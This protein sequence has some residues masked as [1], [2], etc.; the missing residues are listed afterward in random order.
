M[1]PARPAAVVVLAAGEG[2]RMKSSIPKVLHPLGGRTP[3]RPR[4]RRRR[5][6]SSPSTSSSSSATAA[7]RSR[8]TWPRSPPRRVT[9][10]QDEQPAPATPSQCALDGAA[11]DLDRHRRG[12]LRRRAAADRARRCAELARRARRAAATP[13]PCSPRVLADPTGYGRIVRDA[14]GTVER[15]RRAEGRHRRRAARDPRDQHRHLRLRRRPRCAT[16]SAAL[17][18]DNAQ[19]EEYLTDVVGASPRGRRPAASAPCAVD[20]RWQTEGVNDRVQLAAPARASST[21]APSSGWM[22]AGVDRRR[23][24]HDLDRRRRRRSSP[25]PSCSPNTQLHGAHH[26]RDRRRG[27]PRHHAD[28]HRGRRRR[29]ASS[30]RTADGAVIGPGATVGPYTYLR[31][32]TRLGAAAPRSAASSR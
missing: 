28:R 17:D 16:R 13:S 27:R 10:V 24:G 5:G 9:A 25:T 8:R 15:D 4:G 32:G 2:T 31:P 29:A 18:T 1:S 3:G 11:R 14:D 19:G 26:G 30:A 22:R 6:R 23:P 7:T 12:H 21:A 20:D